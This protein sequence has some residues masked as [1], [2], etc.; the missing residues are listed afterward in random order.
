MIACISIVGKDERLQI[1][2]IRLTFTTIHSKEGMV[3]GKW[4]EKSHLSIH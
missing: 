2:L 4:R 1:A 3:A